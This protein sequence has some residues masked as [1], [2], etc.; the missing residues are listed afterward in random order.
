[1][2]GVVQGVVLVSS[3]TLLIHNIL[4]NVLSRPHFVRDKKGHKVQTN[5]KNVIIEDILRTKV[6][7]P[8]RVVKENALLGATKYVHKVVLYDVN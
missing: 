3:N 4:K 2:V 1:M 7:S 6:Y 5:D 8:Y